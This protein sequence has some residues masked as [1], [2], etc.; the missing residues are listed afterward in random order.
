MLAL[1]IRLFNLPNDY[2]LKI[3]HRVEL[4]SSYE[5]RVLRL[6]LSMQNINLGS[7][8]SVN[9]SQSMF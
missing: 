2:E 7:S 9:P 5:L 4:E 6:G 1:R 8:F 3:S